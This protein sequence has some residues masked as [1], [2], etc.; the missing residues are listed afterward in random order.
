MKGVKKPSWATSTKELNKWKKAQGIFMFSGNQCQVMIMDLDDP[1]GILIQKP[2]RISRDDGVI[3]GSF[4]LNEFEVKA[5][6][7]KKQEV[8]PYYFA[9]PY[10]R[11]ARC[12]VYQ[13]NGAQ[14]PLILSNPDIR[15][16]E[17]KDRERCK[18]V[19]ELENA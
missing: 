14:L 7:Q 5:G 8:K 3:V 16:V 19:L 18:K 6:K 15:Y 9:A 11:H 1:I 17:G 2:V 12:F 4:C 10:A 13:A